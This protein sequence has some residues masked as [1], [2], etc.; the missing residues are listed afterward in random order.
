LLLPCSDT[1]LRGRIFDIYAAHIFGG[2]AFRSSSST[3]SEAQNPPGGISHRFITDDLRLL[4]G[5]ASL[6]AATMLACAVP[7]RRPAQSDPLKAL[8]EE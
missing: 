7:A 4:I 6:L 5:A 1:A 2:E 3:L 8:R